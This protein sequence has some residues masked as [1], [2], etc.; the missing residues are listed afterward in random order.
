MFYLNINYRIVLTMEINYDLIL[1][2]LYTPKNK[3][4][5]KK[6]IL[7][8]SDQFPEKFKNLLQNKFYRYGIN[9]VDE[10]NN[11]I[12]FFTCLLTLLNKNFITLNNKEELENINIFNKTLKNKEIGY[13]LIQEISDL[14]EI[15]FIIFD[16]KDENIKIIFSNNNQ[17]NSDTPSQYC[18]PYKPTFLIANYE[19]LYEPIIYEL[20]NKRIFSYNDQ[21]IKNL[22]KSDLQTYNNNKYVLQEDNFINEFIDNDQIFT[23]TENKKC[24]S[25]ENTNNLDPLK[26]LKMTKKELN[27]ILNNKNINININKML[28]KDIIDLIL[29]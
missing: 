29:Q 5:S 25:L 2:Y 21:I 15:N 11:N 13:K 23:P 9:H 20:D 27:E 26:L 16:F 18:N 17:N 14:L 28:K 10:K 19:E 24:N 6:H 1:K 22:Y 3:F 8:Y 4:A 7:I 12:S